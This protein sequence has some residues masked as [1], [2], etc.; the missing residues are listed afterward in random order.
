MK[1][2]KQREI[3]HEW[4]RAEI[5]PQR[6]PL[7][8][9]NALQTNWPRCIYRVRNFANCRVALNQRQIRPLVSNGFRRR[10]FADRK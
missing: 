6:R 7:L 8:T 5:R 2:R 3:A 10:L 1:Q 9:N 4:G